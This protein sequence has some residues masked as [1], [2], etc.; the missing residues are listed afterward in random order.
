MKIEKILEQGVLVLPQLSLWSGRVHVKQEELGIK[1]PK[2]VTRGGKPIFPPSEIK[3]FGTIKS[4]MMTALEKESVKF[5]RGAYCMD[6]DRLNAFIEKMK[7]LEGQWNHVVARLRPNYDRLFDEWLPTIQPAE[8]QRWIE[9]A[10]L[11]ASEALAKYRF[12]YAVL[13]LEAPT[14]KD[15]VNDSMVGGL[16]GQLWE[17]LAE[18]AKEAEDGLAGKAKVTQRARG[19]FRRIA[20]KAVAVSFIDAAARKLAAYIENELDGLPKTGPI[21]GSSLDHLR[22]LAHSLAQPEKARGLAKSFSAT[23][24]STQ[25]DM[26]EDQADAADEEAADTNTVEAV[27]AEAAEEQSEPVGVFQ[28]RFF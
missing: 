6:G 18:I 23:A 17:E 7:A 8:W 27:T 19:P 5:G 25:F 16:A 1:L 26:D 14:G 28:K 10:K 2:G 15:G 3:E 4:Q 12:Q 13:R 11:P 21:E 9:R 22:V 20:S 24:S